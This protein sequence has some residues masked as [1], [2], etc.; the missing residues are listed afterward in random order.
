M[1][2]PNVYVNGLALCTLGNISSQEMARD[3]A[4]EVEKLM[5]SQ[6][7]YVRKKVGAG[8]SASA[9][10]AVARATAFAPLPD[11]SPHRG[12]APGRVAHWVVQAYLCAVRIMRKVPE[13]YENFVARAKN[14]FQERNHATI[15]T[16]LT[17]VHELLHV[18]PSLTEQF[19]AVRNPPAQ[20]APKAG[21]D[22]S[23]AKGRA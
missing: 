7:A 6:S 11:S 14:V 5:A 10:A 12:H 4:T 16:G 2:H 15:L 18:D 21:G 8:A 17:L 1:N 23:C 22:R 19:R 13:L 3:L 20:Q 9:S